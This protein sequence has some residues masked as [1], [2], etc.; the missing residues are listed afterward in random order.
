MNFG[1]LVLLLFASIPVS[2]I[3]GI[4]VARREFIDGNTGQGLTVVGAMI[5]ALA[6]L[7][8][9]AIEVIKFVR[10]GGL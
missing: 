8:I 4:R 5:I 6:M 2:A 9:P 7:S 1:F 10:S 3:V